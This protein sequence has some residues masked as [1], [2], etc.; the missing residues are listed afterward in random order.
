MEKEIKLTTKL[1]EVVYRK[2]YLDAIGIKKKMPWLIALGV[3]LI[4]AD[5][6]LFIMGELN[7]IVD[8]LYFVLL[9]VILIA[10][11]LFMYFILP[12]MQ[13]NSKSVL[14]NMNYGFIFNSE[15]FTVEAI[16]NGSKSNSIIKYEKLNKVKESKYNVLIYITNNQFYILDKN[17]C[18]ENIQ[19]VIVLL[20]SKVKKYKVV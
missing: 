9:P 10:M 11:I 13:Y 17:Q 8:I 20:K 7:D 3:I 6:M 16:S 4:I 12:K 2:A 14:Y 19:E 18:N 1:D 5:S 15:G